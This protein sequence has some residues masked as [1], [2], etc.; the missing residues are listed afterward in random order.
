MRGDRDYDELNRRQSD[1]TT[2]LQSMRMKVKVT[3]IRQ[4]MLDER[5]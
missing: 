5:T 3:N 1:S 4:L 2:L